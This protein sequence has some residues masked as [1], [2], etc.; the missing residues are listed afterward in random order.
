MASTFESVLKSLYGEADEI[1]RDKCE[2]LYKYMIQDKYRAVL[3]AKQEA[4]RSG[5]IEAGNYMH[6]VG[7]HRRAR[8]L[9]ALA[10]KK[11]DV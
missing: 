1:F 5:L 8:E 9:Y 6:K 11:P 7:E 2:Q 10:D 3:L 4:R